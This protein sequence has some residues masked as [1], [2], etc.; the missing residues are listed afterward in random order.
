M[1]AN[2]AVPQQQPLDQQ[3]PGAPAA[4]GAPLRVAVTDPIISRFAG[5]LTQ[6]LENHEWLFAAGAAPEDRLAAVA[7]ADVVVCSHLSRD[8]A[9]AAV[10]ARLVQVTGASLDRV[11]VGAL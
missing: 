6:G 4:A 1:P 7:G 3:P 8:E 5:R 10:R 11:A 9:E 2:D